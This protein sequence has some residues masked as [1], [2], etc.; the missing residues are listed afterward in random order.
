MPTFTSDIFARV[1]AKKCVNGGQGPF[2]V[3]G[4]AISAK[5]KNCF[6]SPGHQIVSDTKKVYETKKVHFDEIYL[7]YGLRFKLGCLVQAPEPTKTG[8]RP[9]S[10]FHWH[11]DGCNSFD[12]QCHQ[13]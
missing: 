10:P 7:E 9:N 2:F 8:F 13:Y 5:S 3:D 11:K 6:W 12:W 4:Q 1:W